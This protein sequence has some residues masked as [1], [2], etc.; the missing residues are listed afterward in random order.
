MGLSEKEG[1]LNS[2]YAP[3]QSRRFPSQIPNGRP[4]AR[5]PACWKAR[6]GYQ[7]SRR[8]A[9]LDQGSLTLS[10]WIIA[11]GMFVAACTLLQW[12]CADVGERMSARVGPK[13]MKRIYLN[14]CVAKDNY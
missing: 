4:E 8:A 13:N 10:F 6:A 14:K 5:A 2:I 12:R 1:K 11:R 9:Q 3:T 7:V